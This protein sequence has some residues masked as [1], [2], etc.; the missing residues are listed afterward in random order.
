[1]AH[2]LIHSKDTYIH[3]FMKFLDLV[4]LKKLLLLA[5]SCTSTQTARIYDK[6]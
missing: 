2:K 1:M 4:N 5:G 3:T 6:I